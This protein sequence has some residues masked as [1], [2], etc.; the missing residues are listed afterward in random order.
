[1][2]LIL[3]HLKP[4]K[5]LVFFTITFVAVSSLLNLVLPD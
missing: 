4:H 5:L 3:Q 2:K 1:M